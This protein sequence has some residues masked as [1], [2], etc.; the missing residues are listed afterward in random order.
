LI[1][2]LFTFYVMFLGYR[3]LFHD[4]HFNLSTVTKHM[5]VMLCTYGMVMHWDLYHLFVY[6]IFTNEPAHITEILID[7][8]GKLHGSESIAQA[9]DDIYAAIV[10]AAMGFFGEI[11]FSAAG[12]AFLIY[13]LLVFLIGS[14]LCLFALLLFVY[15]KMM[16]A[17]ALALG[18]LFIL[19]ILWDST[20]G[21]FSAWL[22]KLIT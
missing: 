8:S 1:S 17:I 11:S 7:S 6:D 4:H 10:K 12:L 20:K 16:M 14:L 5:V 18:P 21:I 2:L 19:F 22:K 15:A 3:F 13:G 9:L